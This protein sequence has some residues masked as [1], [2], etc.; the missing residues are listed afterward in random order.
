LTLPESC[1]GL[2]GGF[3]ELAVVAEELG[4]VVCPGPL[5][6]T[7]GGFVPVVRELG[8]EAQQQAYLTPVAEGRTTG[9]VAL[10]E[11]AGRWRPADVTTEARRAGDGWTLH[12]TKAFVVEGAAVDQLAVIARDAGTAGDDGLGVWIV[13]TSMVETHIVRSLDGSRQL[14]TVVLDGVGVPADARLGDP[15]A[16]A[17][18]GLER[19]L[20]EVTVALALETVGVC[21]SIFE[22]ATQYAKDRQQFGVPIGSFQAMKHKFA[23]MLVT[24]QRARAACYFAVATIA[25]DD[26]RRAVATA[27]AKAAAGDCQALVAQ[28][29]IQS[30]GGIGYTWEHDMH[31]YVKRAKTCDALFGSPRVHRAAVADALGL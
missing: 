8:T 14:A 22:I 6:A 9:S 15:G 3:V 4:R 30:L 10:A 21:Q 20:Q 12:G 17:R 27:M 7:V 29:G 2:G 24:L 16:A 13:P 11:S 5:L 19:A 31:L 23:N 26:D 25:E 1:G 28:E 18:D